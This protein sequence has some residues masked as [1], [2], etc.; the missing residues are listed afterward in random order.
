MT[1]IDWLLPSDNA[2]GAMI[3]MGLFFSFVEQYLVTVARQ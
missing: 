3:P 1:I 2:W